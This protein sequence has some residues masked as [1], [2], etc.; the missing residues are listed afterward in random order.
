M[1]L[2]SDKSGD[3]GSLFEIRHKSPALHI[4]SIAVSRHYESGSLTD[5]IKRAAFVLLLS[6][7]DGDRGNLFEYK[8]RFLY[9]E[10]LITQN[11]V[12]SCYQSSSQSKFAL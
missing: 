1:L 8:I 3:R 7:K 5:A 11:Q 2:L 6:D 9:L 4:D 10:I 12:F